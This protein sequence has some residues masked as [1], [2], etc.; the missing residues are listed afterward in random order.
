MTLLAVLLLIV[1]V[2]G[3]LVVPF[4]VGLVRGPRS[5]AGAPDPDAAG[6]AVPMRPLGTIARIYGGFMLLYLLG[7]VL[8]AK[9]GFYGSGVQR[10]A[11]CVTAG[12]GGPSSADA[13]PWRARPGSSLGGTGDL[14]ACVLHPTAGQWAQLALTKVP[15]LLLWGAVLLMIVRLV[16]HAAQHGPFTP[17]AAALMRRLGWLILAG[18]ALVGALGTVGTLVLTDMV[19]TPQPYDPP[20]IVLGALIWEPLRALFPVPALAGVALLAFASV[21]RVGAVMDEELRATV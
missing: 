15:S 5:S 6:L 14:Q 19:L 8:E 11:A 1:L 21:T 16:R 13:Q 20:G 7:A 18:C 12:I 3:Y 10:G 2:V 4:G 17:R 9:D